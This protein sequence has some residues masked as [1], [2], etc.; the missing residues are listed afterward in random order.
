MARPDPE[1][2]LRL[3]AD[4]LAVALSREDGRGRP[5]G[6][7]AETTIEAIEQ[8]GAALALVG[9]CSEAA[10][11]HALADLVLM[12]GLRDLPGGSL[13][14][15]VIDDDPVDSGAGVAQ[16]GPEL[17]V[18][19]GLRCS[20][21]ACDL[22]VGWLVRTAS[23]T[24]LH[25]DAR[26]FPG[27]A[28]G[29][30]RA[31]SGPPPIDDLIAVDDAGNAYRVEWGAHGVE[32]AGTVGEALLVPDPPV[33]TA[34]L[35]LRPPKVDPLRVHLHRAGRV[36]TGREDSPWTPPAERYLTHLASRRGRGHPWAGWSG[37]ASEGERCEARICDAFVALGLV[38]PD[39][40][41]VR[42][43]GGERLAATGDGSGPDGWARESPWAAPAEGGEERYATRALGA[44]LP[45]ERIR[46][47]LEGATL[48]EHELSIWVHV[49]PV[50]RARPR[51][52]GAAHPEEDPPWL[53]AHD[54]R[55]RAYEAVRAHWFSGEGGASGELA[56][57]PGL[58][59]D[60]RTLRVVAETPY[61][62]AWAEVEVPGR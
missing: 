49:S 51:P 58:G 32:V 36:R 54:E 35:E 53:R 1:V 3:C 5:G 50:P 14:P 22:R 59:D 30:R 48:V 13:E 4:D 45:L 43:L 20:L 33:D 34:W 12:L 2:Y 18:D 40:E 39:H 8:V 56:F 46:V 23:R 37:G 25:A 62:A 47:V 29:A 61:E 10:V 11:E 55:G 27:P 38:A 44:E 57:T 17:V 7:P 26:E 16:H 6:E 24:F 42:I 19:C 52:L 9:A 31:R 41:A 28:G 21:G 60:V 15:V